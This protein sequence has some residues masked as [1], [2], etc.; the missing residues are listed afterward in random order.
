MDFTLHPASEGGHEH[1]Y[2]A[3]FEAERCLMDR[4]DRIAML[5][6]CMISHV[7]RSE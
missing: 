4:R 5:L 7:W 6:Q 3:I 1:E 2:L